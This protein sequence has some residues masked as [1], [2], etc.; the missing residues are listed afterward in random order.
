MVGRR[1][2]GD[3]NVDGKRSVMLKWIFINYDMKL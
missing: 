1:Q 3:T 2:L